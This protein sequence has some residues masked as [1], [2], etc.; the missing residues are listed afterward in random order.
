ME[1]RTLAWGVGTAAAL[2]LFVWLLLPSAVGVEVATVRRETLTVDVEEQGRTRVRASYVVAAPIHGR[3]LRTAVD[4]GDRVEQADVLATMVPAPEDPRVQ[5]EIRAAL[6]AAE[7]REREARAVQRE[8]ESASARA[9][10]EAERREQLFAQGAVSSETREQY[11]QAAQAAEAQLATARA[12]LRASRAEVERARA[13]LIG[14]DIGVE[15]GEGRTRTLRAPV[16]GTVL[17]VHEESERVVAAGTPLFEVSSREG[18]EVI[19]DVLTEQAVRVRPGAPVRISGWGGDVV[20]EGRVRYVEPKGFEEISALGVEEQRVNVIIDLVAAP[21]ELGAEFRV[22]AAIEIWRGE[23]VLTVP[24]SAIFRRGR[25]WR[26]FVSNGSRAELRTVE[27]GHRG[28]ER[29]E[30]L[31]GLEDGERVV[32]FPSDLIEDGVRLDP[33]PVFEEMEP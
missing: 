16:A 12:S 33:R 22:E 28:V 5:A 15:N 18:L 10:R 14:Q 25:G 32:V 21:G 29:A 13:R 2:A 17:V 11:E 19:V 1:R 30:V 4:E 26:T 23:D 31:G 9:N 24:T 6:V 7:A 20:L 8:A 27:I 3:L